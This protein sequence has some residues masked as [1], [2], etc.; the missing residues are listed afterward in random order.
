AAYGIKQSVDVRE[1]LG[2]VKLGLADA[3]KQIGN[4]DLALAYAEDAI[5]L[6]PAAVKTRTFFFDLL[7][8]LAQSSVESG[9]VLGGKRFLERA[10]ALEDG[11]LFLDVGEFDIIRHDICRLSEGL[12]EQ[13]MNDLDFA[14]ALGH[15]NAVLVHEPDNENAKNL[16]IVASLYVTIIETRWGGALI[17]RN[18]LD[19]ALSIFEM[20]SR[21]TESILVDPVILLGANDTVTVGERGVA[22]AGEATL[23]ERPYLALRNLSEAL[24]FPQFSGDDSEITLEMIDEVLAEKFD[25]VIDFDACE[26]VCVLPNGKTIDVKHVYAPHIYPATGRAPASQDNQFSRN[27]A[28]RVPFGANPVII[29]AQMTRYLKTWDD[30][31]RARQ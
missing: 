4:G 24:S 23:E 22:L 19:E 1:K 26:T 13:A 9:D 11:P 8:D 2:A 14:G 28:N 15:L 6:Q 12:G 30:L 7:R 18:C 16:R 20:L 10:A 3:N 21:G 5:A 17:S 31:K 29:D 25:D 27:P